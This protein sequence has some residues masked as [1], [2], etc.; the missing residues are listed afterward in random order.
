MTRDAIRTGAMLTALL[1]SVTVGAT[2][3]LADQTPLRPHPAPGAVR[4]RAGAPARFAHIR[5]HRRSPGSRTPRPFRSSG[6]YSPA[7][8][9]LRRWRSTPPW[10]L[11]TSSR[12]G[13]AGRG[14]RC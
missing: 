12:P 7:P 6:R 3:A 11:A 10:R 2:S 13:A 8:I 14:W 9:T 1:A 4:A 5:P